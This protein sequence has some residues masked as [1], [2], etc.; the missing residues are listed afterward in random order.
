MG[1]E[2]RM[3]RR[4]LV[5]GAMGL[6]AGL[7]IAAAPRLLRAAP[8][9]SPVTLTLYA[10][11]H[12]QMVDMINAAFTK[13]TGIAVRTRQGEAPELASQ[14]VKEG[15]ASPA[16]VFFT[17]NSP[18]LVLLDEHKLLAKVDPATLSQV[19]AKYSAADGSWVGVLARENVLAF[20]PKLIQESQLPASLL[21][22]SGVAW[23]GKVAIAPA[24]ADFLPLVSAVVTLKG[25]TA[26]LAWLRGLKTNAQVFDD[27]EGVVA[28]VERGGVA[29]GIVNNY[30][31]ARLRTEKG[32]G[33]TVSQIHHFANG[34]VGALINV[35]GA[36]VMH[37]SRHQAE[38]QKYLAFLVS[39]DMQAALGASD[40]DYEYPLVAGA[41]PNPLL[42]PF[43]QL[44]PPSVS[45]AQ[46][47][48]DRESGRLLRQAGLL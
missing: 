8:A 19:P 22:L 17:E 14:L 1:A 42:R 12:Q 5:R 35:S 43:E 18:E 41:A 44:Q 25:R 47:G 32:A 11:Q 28:A 48:D 31:W 3:T 39:K 20:N 16:D 9:A 2:S 29:T 34:D 38:A 21:D 13:A 36:A 24:D 10:A 26:A 40:I 15:A 27:D 7:G 37:A 30:Y 46:L 45:M 23:K 33:K 6:A 4:G